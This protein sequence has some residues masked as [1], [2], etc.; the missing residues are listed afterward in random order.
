MHGLSSVCRSV[1]GACPQRVRPLYPLSLSSLARSNP[2]AGS[3]LAEPEPEP[4]PEPAPAPEP[5]P[6]PEPEPL[7][8]AS[9]TNQTAS[10]TTALPPAAPPAPPPPG[11]RETLVA[12][13]TDA[14]W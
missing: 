3:V 6:K 1:P 2:F 5:E 11:W 7:A 13:G 12:E 9:S 4:E 8:N 14:E 10:N